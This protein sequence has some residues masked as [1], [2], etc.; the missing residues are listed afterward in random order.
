MVQPFQQQHGNQSSPNLNQQCVAAGSHKTLHLQ[1]LFQRL[2]QLTYIMPINFV[3]RK[4]Q[5]TTDFIRCAD[6]RFV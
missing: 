3:P 2:E 1:I 4:S 6:K 5:S